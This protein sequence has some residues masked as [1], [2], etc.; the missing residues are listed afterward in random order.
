MKGKVMD[1]MIE[2]KEEEDVPLRSSLLSPFLYGLRIPNVVLML[3]GGW[4]VVIMVLVPTYDIWYILLIAFVIIVM[5]QPNFPQV[6]R[7][8]CAN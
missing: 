4:L 5:P 6:L 7:M 2:A 1:A 3:C 8:H